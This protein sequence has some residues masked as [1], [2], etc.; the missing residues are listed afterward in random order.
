MRFVEVVGALK[1]GKK[2]KLE[3]WKN[4]YW[5]ERMVSLSTTMK[6]VLSVRLQKF[7]LTL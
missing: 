4:A 3:K 1:E 7:Y 2:I 6:T 5:Y